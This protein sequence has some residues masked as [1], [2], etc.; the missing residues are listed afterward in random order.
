MN[1]DGFPSSANDSATYDD[2]NSDEEEE[3]A[4]IGAATWFGYTFFT[5]S[6]RRRRHTSALSGLLKVEELLTGHPDVMYN[7]VRMD[8]HTFKSLGALLQEQGLLRSSRAIS[9]HELLFIFLT[10]VCQSQTNREAQDCWQHSAETISRWFNELL[11][12][13]CELRAEIITPPPYHEVQHFITINSHKYR[14][15]FDVRKD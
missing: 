2:I 6:P 12:A 4:A 9:V 3:V 1:N 14:P 5:R 15:W 11:E 8:A 10:I 13:I 7:K